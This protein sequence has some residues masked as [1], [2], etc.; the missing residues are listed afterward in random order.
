[1]NHD[2]A[3]P[4]LLAFTEGHLGEE[5]ARGVRAHADACGACANVLRVDALL[6]ADV[7]RHGDA[8]FTPHPASADLVSAV[9]LDGRLG[10][11]AREE[12]ARHMTAC[13]SCREEANLVRGATAEHAAP[14]WK[15][16]WAAPPARAILVPALGALVIG[17]AVPAYRGVIEM[18]R[19]REEQARTE[20]ELGDARAQ[21]RALAERL[22]AAERGRRVNAPPAP[23][24]VTGGLATPLYL[25]RPSRDGGE[26]MP[27][28][29]IRPGTTLLPILISYDPLADAALSP[30]RPLTIDVRALRTGRRVWTLRV[31]A[32]D[33]ADPVY[34]TMTLLV[35]HEALS[36]GS[37]AL[38]VRGAPRGEAEYR[39]EFRV[40]D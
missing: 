24:A 35:P 2:T 10:G 33:A 11:E 6:R 23:P 18:P 27:E 25:L 30:T 34:H 17:L 16:G 5:E 29:A 9:L 40:T 28:I 20:A 37:Y 1:L 15:R 32:R 39:A 8:Y 31:P 13:T 19:V 7:E 4:L 21:A 14:W 22:R 36:P 38:T 3:A 26:P 12:I